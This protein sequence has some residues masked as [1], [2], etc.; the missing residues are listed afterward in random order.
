VLRD[1]RQ[2]FRRLGRTP[3]FTAAAVLCLAL[4][5]G[6]NTAIFTVINAVLM[7]PLPY[8]EPE[9]LVWV[10]E[11]NAS[12]ESE[13]NSV[14]PANYLDWKAESSAFSSMAAM[15]NAN[16]GLTG[17][18]E[19]EEIPAQI[20]TASLFPL[21]GLTPLLGR[22]FTAEED[23]APDGA[24]VVVLS[25]GLWL[26]RFGGERG[27]IGRSIALDGAQHTVVGVLPPEARIP[28]IQPAPEVWIPMGLDPAENYRAS[29][30]RYM[31]A[32]ARLA[33]GVSV[34]RAQAELRTIAARLT[35]R[36]PDFNTG[37][38]VNLVPMTEQVVGAVR[39]PLLVLGAVVALVLLISC[40]NVA[41]LQLAQAT[42]R[43]REIAVRT[44]LGASAAQVARQ[45]LAESLLV[46]LAGGGLGILLA[47]WGT[48]AF[49][50]AASADIP[51]VEEIGVDLR[52]LGFTLIVSLVA[53][54]AFGMV[55]ALHAA[56]ADS[57]EFLREG[58]R[59]ASSGGGRTRAMLVGAQVALSLILLVGAGLLL[60]SVARLQ[61]VE[62]G[63]NPDS[64]LTARVSLGGAKYEEPERQVRFFEEL[65]T[66]VRSTPGVRAAG[67]I[68]WLPLSG[69]RSATRMTIEGEPVP[70]PGSEPGADVRAID[71]G[72]LPAMQIPLLRGRT[73][74][75]SD[76]RDT[77]RAV[78][79]SQSFVE[80][81]IPSGDPLGRRIHMEWGDTL[82]GTVVGVVGDL[83]HTG[84]D[85]IPEPTVYWALPQFPSP[86]MTLVIRTSDDP[87]S[88]AGTL[89]AEV[90]SMDPAQPLAEIKPFDEYLDNA[91]ARR[92]FTMT[93]LGGF[94][95]LALVLTAIGLYGTA[96][97]A[98]VQRTRE[99]GIRLALGAQGRDVLWGV[100]RRSL[101]VTA[102][103]VIVGLV[104]AVVATRVLA[105]LLFD[106]SATDPA[107][108]AAIAMVL[109]LVALLASYLPARRATRVDPVVALRS[110]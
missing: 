79:V 106:V 45:F 17:V 55:P 32:A 44:A 52:A 21:L 105:T 74:A 11:A 14:S 48:D 36:H 78:V 85:S 39:R 94:A 30:G 93:L 75:P 71:P 33:P 100:L 42:V 95:V 87:M 13:R 9:R 8:H 67:A 43:R 65:L 60:K 81:F 110:E 22:G 91:V 102:A 101:A 92:R 24:P 4:G 104:G 16:L 18:G 50:A 37:W 23:A 35:E 38:S 5:I 3:A 84:L 76:T 28:D 34:D 49:A 56:R 88:L 61:N 47:I 82:I 64:L 77:P 26:R 53:G 57:Q 10:W 86:F 103:G 96:A 31:R 109:A 107:I 6:A 2:A 7:R 63:F 41:N 54:L 66:R 70:A 58:G 51:R 29:S 20:V 73:I 108:F 99:F 89:R 62:V 59:S 90:R 40:A 1:L 15:F 27:V 72:F 80:R 83:K 98:V 97:Y 69:Q 68:N 19:A 46:A 12:R 25:H